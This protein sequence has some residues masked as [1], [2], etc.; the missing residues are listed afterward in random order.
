LDALSGS[1]DFMRHMG[2]LDQATFGTSNKPLGITD[3]TT[4]GIYR[5]A[6]SQNDYEN[7]K[8]I[9]EANNAN[10]ESRMLKNSSGVYDKT[11]KETGSQMESILIEV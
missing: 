10:H 6:S 11:G 3:E 8:K 5:I 2:V 4:R 7:L 9:V 1:I